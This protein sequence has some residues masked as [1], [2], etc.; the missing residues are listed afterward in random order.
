MYCS[1]TKEIHF[2]VDHRSK[3]YISIRNPK[4]GQPIMITAMPT[5]N[6]AKALTQ[7]NYDMLKK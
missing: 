7:S 6:L 3:E 1:E 2:E 4:K 5:K